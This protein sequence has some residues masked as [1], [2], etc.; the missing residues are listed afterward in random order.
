MGKTLAEKILSNKS[1]INA[2]AGD[3][4]IA[5]VDIAFM[6]D[7]TGPLT[8]NQFYEAGFSK[9]SALTKSAVFLDHAAPSPNSNLSNDHVSLRNFAMDT[10]TLLSDVG[11]GI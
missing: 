1:G 6:Q 8:V 5:G 7:T 4:V 2:F 9:I 3:I 10:G 11:N